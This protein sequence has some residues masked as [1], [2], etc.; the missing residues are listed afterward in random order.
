[1]TSRIDAERA[2]DAIVA[3]WEQNGFGVW[4]ISSRDG[5]AVLG[6][7]GLSKKLIGEEVRINL[8]YR[9]DHPFW[10]NGYAT[11]FA[12]WI[13]DHERSE[14][15]LEEIYGLVRPHHDASIRVLEKTGFKPCGSVNDVP[16]EDPSLLYRWRQTAD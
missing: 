9:F 16:E 8:G 15:E 7:G 1:M 13:C 12:Q 4:R 2:I 10:G 11:E 5:N 6:F 3:H 14:L